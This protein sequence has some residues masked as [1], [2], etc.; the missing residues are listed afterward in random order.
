MW[1]ASQP[2]Q[3]T[4]QTAG[5]YW[6]FSQTRWPTIASPTLN[7]VCASNLMVNGTTPSSNTI[8]ANLIPLVSNGAGPG[9]QCGAIVNLAA[10]STVYL[11]VWQSSGGSLTLPTNF[12][13]TF[14]GAIF[15]TPSL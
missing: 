12:G 5:I 14:L 6:L 15:L 2:T 7:T 8:A 13:G 9:N 4:V 1:V 11:D 10:G 3:L